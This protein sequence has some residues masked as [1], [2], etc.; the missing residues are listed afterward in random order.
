MVQEGNLQGLYVHIPF[1]IRR[2]RYCSFYSTTGEIDQDRCLSSLF[3]H[4]DYLVEKFGFYP[5][6]DTLY[7]GG[8]TP[9]LM[10][11]NFFNRF[12]VNLNKRMIDIK[13]IE[14]IT[15]EANP[16]TLSKDYLKGLKDLGINR[17]S[18]GVQSTDVNILKKLD[19]VHDVKKAYEAVE[20]ALNIF[21]NVSVDF[22]IGIKGQEDK[23]IQEIFDFPFLKDIK[24]ISVY[25][26]EGEKN[27][28]IKCDDDKAA[29]MYKQTVSF[30]ESKGFEQYEISNFAKKGYESLHNSLYWKGNNYLGIGVSSHSF[31][32][33]KDKGIRFAE[34]SDY[35]VF[36][37]NGFS[38]EV[39]QI[40]FND[41]VREF[42]MLGL[43]RKQGIV[44]EEFKVKWGI[45][46]VEYF[47]P[48][49]ESFSDF[50]I[51]EEGRV[52]LSVEGFL[53]SNEIF[54]EILF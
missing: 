19:R 51:Q 47:K 32:L 52:R 8:G 21:D 2:C 26:L 12:L 50:F 44:I 40:D 53:L 13:N 49:I 30:L 11:L 14:E 43:R 36:L 45:N 48:V 10:S 20:C 5:Q 6:F 9:S 37:E 28:S 29:E 42:F 3:A 7:F 4:F 17:V 15:I 1:C 35:V 18:I 22:I 31:K 33:Q 39:Y 38:Q 54:E 25:M 24:H 41:L 34:K 16:E 27:K 46:P 23:T